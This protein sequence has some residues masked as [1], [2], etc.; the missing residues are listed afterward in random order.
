VADRSIT[1]GIDLASRP[2]NTALCAIEWGGPQPIIR[3][4]YLGQQDGTLLHD[5]FLVTTIC[6]LRLDF[7]GAPIVKT[8]IDSPFGWPAPF[9][10]AVRAHSN[11]EGWGW[12]IDDSRALFERRE[13]DRF[14]ETEFGK[15]PLSVSGDKIGVVAMRCAV[16]LNYIRERDGAAAVD[17]VGTGRVCETYPDP[18]LRAWTDGDPRSLMPR[19]SYRGV[20]RAARRE[21]LI[22]LISERADLSD[23]AGLLAL[24]AA[25]DHCLDALICA[26]VARAA[27]LGLTAVPPALP[28]AAHSEG[29]IHVP[30]CPL[31]ALIDPPAYWH[32]PPT[33]WRHG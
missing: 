23:P 27:W 21:D 33:P 22:N 12:N 6:E 10:E 13:T 19:E 5:K 20:D 28:G 16:L 1:L 25:R 24:C 18:A 7:E 15:R 14:V 32:P 2:A 30:T 29:W 17:P 26:L 3:H 4:L 31:Q 9:V 11:G 8:A